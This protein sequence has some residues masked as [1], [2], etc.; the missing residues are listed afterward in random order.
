MT[1]IT[2]LILD[3]HETFRRRFAALD[4]AKGT[5]EIRAIWEPLAALL[6]LHAIAEE[7]IF[8]PQLLRRADDSEGETIDAIG[9][10]NEIRDAVRKA[11]RYPIGTDSWW[12]AVREARVANSDHMAEEEDDGLADFR[13]NG[14]P[15]LRDELG[16]KFAAFKK[17]HAGKRDLDTSDK[18]PEEYVEAVEAGFEGHGDGSLG[19]GSLKGL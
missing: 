9:D 8:Y 11:A 5:T 15:E 1:D 6:D 4:D 10:H 17:D 12:Q 7:E 13:R 14:S 16:N 3:D 18:D 2:K 19:I